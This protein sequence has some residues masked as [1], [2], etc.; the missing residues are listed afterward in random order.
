MRPSQIPLYYSRVSCSC[1]LD[2]KLNLSLQANQGCIFIFSWHGLTVEEGK[3]QAGVLRRRNFRNP[4][5]IKG[6]GNIFPGALKIWGDLTTEEIITPGARNFSQPP[7]CLIFYCIRLVSCMEYWQSQLY[8]LHRHLKM[9]VFGKMK[10]SENVSTLEVAHSG[11]YTMDCEHGIGAI[12]L[13]MLYVPSLAI[14]V[15]WPAN[16]SGLWK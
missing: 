5:F 14:T 11:T 13:P 8:L 6:P 7:H 10:H 9:F 3:E 2:Y 15:H 4:D 1:P 16:N 12:L